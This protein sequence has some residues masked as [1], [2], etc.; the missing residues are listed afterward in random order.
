[1]GGE[2][3][4]KEGRIAAILFKLCIVLSVKILEYDFKQ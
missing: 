3:T 4:K 1:M 2:L